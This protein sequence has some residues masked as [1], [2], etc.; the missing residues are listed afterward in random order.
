MREEVLLN[1]LDLVSEAPRNLNSRNISLDLMDIAKNDLNDLNIKYKPFLYRGKERLK[2]YDQDN[3]VKTY[4]KNFYHNNSKFGF[5][6]SDDKMLTEKYLML[7]NIP[8]TK[9]II[10]EGNELKQAIEYIKINK[11]PYVIKPLNLAGGAGVFVNI[12]L[13]NIENYW[14][15][16]IE[17]Q[18]KYNTAKPQVILQEMITGFEVRVIVTE[19]KALSA[20]LRTPA[21]VIGD[22]KSTIEEL[23]HE[24]NKQKDESGFLFNKK[25]KNND[26]LT[27]Y[28]K[29]KDLSIESVLKNGQLCILNPVTNL[30]NGGENI[31]ITD[32]IHENIMKLAEDAVASIPGIHT[33]GVD[34]MIDSLDDTEGHILEINK[35]PAFQLNYYPYIGKPQEPLKYI[36]SSL[37]LE[38]RVLHD[39]LLLEDLDEKSFALLNERYKALFKKQKQLEEI[40]K[41]LKERSL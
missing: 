13:E 35:A 6:V 22:S 30:V 12:S 25:I 4:V 32:Y 21:Y 16:C 20:T 11:G 39:K 10:L 19:G 28:L 17:V 26:N 23:I 40:I 38:N 1:I 34:V 2:I 27:K 31:V 7:A 24:K 15:Q 3:Y 18:S 29:K 33:A 37:I 5:K 8:T 36:F 9:S 14:E 41:N